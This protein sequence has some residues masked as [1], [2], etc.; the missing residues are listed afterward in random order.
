MAQE[1]TIVADLT[2]IQSEDGGKK[3]NV[4]KSGRAMLTMSSSILLQHG[5][6]LPISYR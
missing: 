5:E 2:K 6:E 4:H 1:A 3:D